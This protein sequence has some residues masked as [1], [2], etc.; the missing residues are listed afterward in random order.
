MTHKW[1]PLSMFVA[2]IVLLIGTLKPIVSSQINYYFS[3][4]SDLI[5]P[6]TNLSADT[7][8]SMWSPDYTD[9]ST[10]FDIPSRSQTNPLTPALNSYTISIPAIKL[11]RASVEVYGTDLKK[12][13]IHYPDTALPGE[14][15]NPVIFG[16]STLPQLYKPLDPLSIFNHLPEV[17]IGDELFVH[18]SD[19]T[20]KYV[21]RDTREVKP[22]EVE[23]LA[24]RYDRREITLITCV[25]LGTYLRRFVVRAE[26]VK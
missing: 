9:V 16:H 7:Y 11:V 22:T 18:L 25:P 21:I 5:D 13:A 4:T 17:T 20:Y 1:L 26:L 2:G 3:D 8:V 12:N 14:F 24:Q 23:V 19:V 6:T 15:G 10:W